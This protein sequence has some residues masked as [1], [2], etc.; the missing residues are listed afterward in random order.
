MPKTIAKSENANLG[1]REKMFKAVLDVVNFVKGKTRTYDLP[2]EFFQNRA[3]WKDIGFFD[4]LVSSHNGVKVM[5]DM[6]N[7][8]ICLKGRND[9]FNE[10]CNKCT[11]AKTKMKREAKVLND[12]QMWGIISNKNEKC[13]HKIMASRK[14]KAKVCIHESDLF[15][16]VS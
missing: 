4:D 10:A 3:F 16:N 11:D 14:I 9:E 12:N 2:D 13:L 8:K 1:W 6:K 15:H 5:E 7:K